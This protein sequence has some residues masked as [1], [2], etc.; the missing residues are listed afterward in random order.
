M[1][2]VKPPVKGGFLFNISYKK[3]RTKLLYLTNS[4]KLNVKAKLLFIREEVIDGILFQSLVLDKTP[5]Y[6]QGGGQPSDVGMIK[7]GSAQF[8][9]EKVYYDKKSDTVLHLGTQIQGYIRE[10]DIVDA[11]V[12]ADLRKIN[13]KYHSAGHIIDLARKNLGLQ[14][15]PIKGYHY[16]E[17]AYLEYAAS[18]DLDTDQLA[19]SLQGEVDRLIALDLKMKVRLATKEECDSDLY[20]CPDWKEITILEIGDMAKDHCGGTHVSG[21]GHLEGLNIKKVKV[22]GDRVKIKYD[23]GGSKLK[24]KGKVV[25]KK[26][27][28]QIAS[29]ELLNI[30]SH[31]IERIDDEKEDLKKLEKEYL[32]KGGIVT[33]LIQEITNKSPEQRAVYGKDVN[34]LKKFIQ[35]KI[36]SIKSQEQAYKREDRKI[37]LTAPFDVNTPVDQRPHLISKLGHKNPLNQELERISEIFLTMGFEVE[38]ARQLDNDYNMFG[39][40]NFPEGHP[41]RDMWDTFHTEEGF[42]PTTHTSTMQNRILKG[43]K[44]PIR[45]IIPG[46]CYRNEAT[47]DRHEHTLMQFEGIYVDKGISL[48]NMVAVMHAFLEEYYQTNLEVKLQ[49]SHFPFVEPGLELCMSCPFCGK[50]GCSTCGHHGWIELVGCGM[51]HPNV[52]REGGIDPDVYSGFAWGFGLD[53]LVMIRTGIKNIRDIRSGNIDFLSQF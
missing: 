53:R 25:M 2:F 19:E 28:K 23:F 52:L 16:K 42:M 44:P 32:G 47:D 46:M 13:S 11:S 37:D 15:T 17:G 8:R 35:G 43:N 48:S 27:N 3:M 12:D 14:L 24:K 51:I 31:F 33:S 6:P 1:L 50:T 45:Y 39:A 7:K 41:A 40:L 21:S 38:D 34:L 29:P 4:E 22:D 26:E 36:E 18:K 20:D 30:K 49:P 9:V 10:G 5:F